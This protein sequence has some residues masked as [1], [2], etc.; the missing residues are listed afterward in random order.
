MFSVLLISW[1]TNL[2]RRRIPQVTQIVGNTDTSDP[3]KET[4]STKM[5]Q[6]LGYAEELEKTTVPIRPRHQRRPKHI[7]CSALA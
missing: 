4:F 5:D 1:A 7:L 3:T 2:K 6:I